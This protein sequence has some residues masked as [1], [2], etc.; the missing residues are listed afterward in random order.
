M[1]S[2]LQSVA[3]PIRRPTTS[4]RERARSTSSGSPSTRARSRTRPTRRRTSRSMS[5]SA[6]A[7]VTSS[8]SRRPTSSPT[9]P[10]ATRPSG[11]PRSARTTRPAS[12]ARSP[13]SRTSSTDARRARPCPRT[14]KVSRCQRGADSI[15]NRCPWVRNP[16]WCMLSGG[17][18]PESGADPPG[19]GLGGGSL[20]FRRRM[21]GPLPSAHGLRAAGRRRS[22]PCRGARRGSPTHPTRR[23]AS[24]PTPGYV[25]PHWPTPWGLDADPIHQTH[26]R[27][28]AAAGRGAPAAEP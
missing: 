5:S 1:T 13:T 8:S 25:A 26:H 3:R 6:T 12:A 7:R 22:A 23:A 20:G 28:R 4:S 10:S 27:R 19:L 16:T 14:A 24:S 21:P 2:P 11:R 18:A 15:S 9:W 17:R